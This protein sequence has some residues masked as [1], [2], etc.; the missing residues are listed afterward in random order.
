[1]YI[2]LY[3]YIYEKI[4]KPLIEVLS[5]M[6]N[7]GIYLIISSVFNLLYGVTGLVSAFKW[8]TDIRQ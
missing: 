7:I 8:K 5:L 6:E 2:T 4:D 1:M 3:A